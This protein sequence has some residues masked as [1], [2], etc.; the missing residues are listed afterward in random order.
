MAKP[1]FEQP[2]HTVEFEHTEYGVNSSVLALSLK[3][4]YLAPVNNWMG[5]RLGVLAISA[6]DYLGPG[7]LGPHFC[8]LDP[9][10][11]LR[12]KVVKVTSAHFSEAVL[13]GR[14]HQSGPRS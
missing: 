1:A 5:D 3:L 13:L 7:D 6:H 11:W 14:G 8:D 4:S 2:E 12:P 10:W 9:L